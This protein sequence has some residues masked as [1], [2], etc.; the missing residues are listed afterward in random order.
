MV[1]VNLENVIREFDTQQVPNREEIT[2][3]N[4]SVLYKRKKFFL[5]ELRHSVKFIGFVLIGIVYLKDLSILRFI[6]RGFSQYTLSN[7]YPTPHIYTDETKRGVTKS[8]L[9]SI[10]GINGFC[11]LMHLIFGVYKK[12]PAGESYLYGGM[13][14][15]F[16][17]ENPP[18]GRLELMTY[19]AMIFFVQIILHCLMCVIDDSVILHQSVINDGDDTIDHTYHPHYHSDGY[20]GRVMLLN[21][22][23]L[24][25]IQTVLNYESNFRPYSS[26]YGT[27]SSQQNENPMSQD[28]AQGLYHNIP[29]GLR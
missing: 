20:N 5:K 3:N 23:I 24:G 6:L 18:L 10:F 19:D 14:V 1:E 7:P 21:L 28:F 8:L 26:I 17:G 11:L 15:E 9:I 27:P 4:A 2:K 29:G 12:S 25:S 16:I 22:D 13:S